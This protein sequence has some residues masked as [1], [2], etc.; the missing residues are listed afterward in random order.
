MVIRTSKDHKKNAN[1]IKD[2]FN[3]ESPKSLSVSLN[4]NGDSF[5]WIS[6]DEI[7]LLHNRNN[8]DQLLEKFKLLPKGM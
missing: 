4:D 2:I 1:S 8:K 5:L 6:Q 3:A 7:W